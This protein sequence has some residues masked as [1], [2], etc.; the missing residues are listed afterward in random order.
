LRSRSAPS[1]PRPLAFADIRFGAANARSRA[2]LGHRP[3]DS[4]AHLLLEITMILLIYYIVFVVVGTVAA[5]MIGIW[6][7]SVSQL[8]SITVFFILFFGLLWGAWVLSVWLTR[9]KEGEEA[10]AVRLP[11]E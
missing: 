4:A 11:A 7:D 6:L 8:V 3:R 9:P 2:A 5:T 10:D 1:A